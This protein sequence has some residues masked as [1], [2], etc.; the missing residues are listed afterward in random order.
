MRVA[1]VL[2]CAFSLLVPCL[3]LG[4]GTQSPPSTDAP[5]TN[6]VRVNYVPPTNPAHQDIYDLMKK[7]GTLERMQK[8]LSPFRLEGRSDAHSAELRHG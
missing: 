6:R 7:R 4:Q 1:R 3:A 8:L 5:Q 2:A